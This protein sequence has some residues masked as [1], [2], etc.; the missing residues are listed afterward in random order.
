ML[1]RLRFLRIFKWLFGGCFAE[2]KKLVMIF[3]LFKNSKNRLYFF[4]IL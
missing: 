2:S 1:L 3:F 4:N